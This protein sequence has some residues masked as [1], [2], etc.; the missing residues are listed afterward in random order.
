[1]HKNKSDRNTEAETIDQKTF[2]LSDCTGDV[3]FNDD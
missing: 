2:K 1:M 3:K